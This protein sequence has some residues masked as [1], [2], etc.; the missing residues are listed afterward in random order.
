MGHKASKLL[1][2]AGVIPKNTMQ[3]LVNWCL[4]PQDYAE[5]HGARP[6][7]LDTANPEEVS[8]FVGDLGKALVR[9]M[10]EI[11]ETDLNRSGS[12]K[13]AVLYFSDQNLDGS[14]QDVFV[15]CLGRII[16]PQ[17]EPWLRLTAAHFEGESSPRKAVRKEP[18]YDGE[19]LTAQVVYLEAKGVSDAGL[20]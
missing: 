19:V 16:T 12:Y 4:L 3:E 6:L 1:I 2:E 10:A 7:R 14:V 17:G 13:K 20:D 9:D 18:R 11:R 15:D 8:R 5:S